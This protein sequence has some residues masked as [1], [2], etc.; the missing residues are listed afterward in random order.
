MRSDHLEHH[1]LSVLR[2]PE[3]KVATESEEDGSVTN[4]TKHDSKEE[5]E[6]DDREETRV[7]LLVVGNTISLNNFLSRS[8]KTVGN[9]MCGESLSTSGYKLSN[10]MFSGIFKFNQSSL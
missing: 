1:I 2:N 8:R 6:G 5:G 4:I 3:D 9:K 7:G 10:S